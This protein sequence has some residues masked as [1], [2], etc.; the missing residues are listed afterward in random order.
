MNEVS[1]MNSTFDLLVNLE[2]IFVIDLHSFARY[3]ITHNTKNGISQEINLHLWVYV[4]MPIVLNNFF[5]RRWKKK[6]NQISCRLSGGYSFHSKKGVCLSPM[7]G[8]VGW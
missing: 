1:L 4:F 2:W 3:K 6:S 5:I 8:L 7:V